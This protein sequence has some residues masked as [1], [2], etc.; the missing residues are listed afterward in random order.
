[1]IME[2]EEIKAK[3]ASSE[4]DFLRT[5]EHLGNRVILLGLGGSHAYGT[6]VAGSDVDIRG[7]ALNSPEEILLG[8]DFEQ[9]TDATT[10][11]TIYSIKNHHN[12]SLM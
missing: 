3:V 4:Y 1:M 9:V 6:N 11:T 10:D 5:N 7:V 2:I 12:H 8:K